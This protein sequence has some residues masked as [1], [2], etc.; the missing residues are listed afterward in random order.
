MKK[1][2]QFWVKINTWETKRGRKNDLGLRHEAWRNAQELHQETLTPRLEVAQQAMS[3]WEKRAR[4]PFGQ[5]AGAVKMVAVSLD[6]L[7]VAR[8]SIGNQSTVGALVDVDGIRLVGYLQGYAA[9]WDDF[10]QVLGQPVEDQVPTNETSHFL[11]H[12]CQHYQFRPRN[13][14]D[15]IRLTPPSIMYCKL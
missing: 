9:V 4:Y 13:L 5:D 11:H 2:A 8:A 6:T 15:P 10:M 7:H 1:P 12:D 14:F 3:R